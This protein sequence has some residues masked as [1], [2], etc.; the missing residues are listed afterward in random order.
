MPRVYLVDE[1]IGSARLAMESVP[2][3]DLGL[4]IN[5]S[6]SV[7]EV[8]AKVLDGMTLADGGNQGTSQSSHDE[9][10]SFLISELRILAYGSGD[11]LFLGWGIHTRNVAQLAPLAPYLRTGASGRCLLVGCNVAMDARRAERFLGGSAIGQRFGSP[12]HGWKPD[13]IGLSQVPGYALLHAL[14]R[15]LGV[16]TTAAL[17]SQ[18][19]AIDWTIMGATLTV[20][21]FGQATFAGMDTPASLWQ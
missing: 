5:P 2:E 12:Y 10:E 15:T 20:D 4:L 11:E 7:T 19:A 8:V 9:P 16:P 18:T 13:E 1:R 21:P 14:A 17:E 6:L 3:G